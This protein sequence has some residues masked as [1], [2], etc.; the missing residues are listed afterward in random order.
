MSI[1]INTYIVLILIFQNKAVIVNFFKKKIRKGGIVYSRLS[2]KYIRI[3]PEHISPVVILVLPDVLHHLTRCIVIVFDVTVKVTDLYPENKILKK[4][5]GNM[6]QNEN[7][8][9]KDHIDPKSGK[10]SPRSVVESGLI[11]IFI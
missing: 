4:S 3:R 2:P 11:Q 8:V 5:G 7:D 6:A 10:I 9:S 1:F